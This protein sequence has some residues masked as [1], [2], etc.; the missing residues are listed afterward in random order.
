MD[1]GLSI[2]DCGLGTVDCGLWIGDCRLWIVDWGLWIVGRGSS[3][4]EGQSSKGEVHSSGGVW[5][6]FLTKF[7]VCIKRNIG[8]HDGFDRPSVPQGGATP[9]L[10]RTH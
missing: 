2:V 4:F 3:E 8:T 1:W 7:A 10:P 9:C 5:K 6:T